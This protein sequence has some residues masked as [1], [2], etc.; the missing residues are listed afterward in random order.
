MCCLSA[1]KSRQSG[2]TSHFFV[3]QGTRDL[4]VSSIDKLLFRPPGNTE[5]WC[6]SVVSKARQCENQLRGVR[7]TRRP[8]S[9]AFV[10]VRNIRE[11]SLSLCGS[12]TPNTGWW[13][14]RL[15][16]GAMLFPLQGICHWTNE[17]V[18]VFGAFDPA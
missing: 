17:E 6:G 4:G 12:A 13:A 15:F 10:W 14:C 8:V 2:M 3:P 11:W 9:R 16:S 18:V 5:S 1:K 7:S